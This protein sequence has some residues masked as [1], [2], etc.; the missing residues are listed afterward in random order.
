V[1]DTAIR[2]LDVGCGAGD[3]AKRLK[4]LRTDRIV[5]GLTNNAAEADI[6]RANCDCVY[7]VDLNTTPLRK[8]EGPFDAIIFSHVLEHLPDPVAVI[9]GLLYLLNPGGLILIV[10]PNVL[11]WRTRFAFIRGRFVYQ[12]SGILDRTHLRFYTPRTAA[13]ELVEPLP[14]LML[15]A[16][17]T[18]GSFPLGP[19]RRVPFLQSLKAFIDRVAAERWPTLFAS[20]VALRAYK[21]GTDK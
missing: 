1:P 6:A 12:D 18:R 10:V 3:N 8:I 7:L 11:E 16:V 9:R 2:I 19:F 14:E 17:G 4:S 20:E 5:V 13:G 21:V 15:D